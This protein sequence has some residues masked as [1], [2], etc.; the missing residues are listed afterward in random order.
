MATLAIAKRRGIDLY[1]W[2]RIRVALVLLALLAGL[3]SLTPREDASAAGVTVTGT[4][5]VIYGD[6]PPGSGLPGQM[7]YTV[8]NASGRR[9]LTIDNSVLN[10]GGGAL[11]L[12][13]KTVRVT[14]NEVSPR[15]IVVQSIGLAGA[16]GASPH[17]RRASLAARRHMQRSS[18]NSQTLLPSR[19]Q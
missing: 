14:G 2:Q 19:R 10:A 7:R 16:D 5:N 11:A 18:V 6:P 9:D 17:P 15:H 12:N 8:S 4:L 13:R 3:G 1:P